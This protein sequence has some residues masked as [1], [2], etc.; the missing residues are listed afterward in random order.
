MECTSARCCP[1]RLRVQVFCVFLWM[2]D[3]YWYY[4]LF[5]LFMLVSFECTL[6]SQRLRNLRELRSLQTPKQHIQVYRC[7][8]SPLLY[9][10]ALNWRERAH[11]EWRRCAALPS[12]TWTRCGKWELLPGEALFPGDV[13]SIGRPS[14]GEPG[15]ASAAPQRLSP[16]A[17]VP[18]A[19]ACWRDV[20]PLCRC[21]R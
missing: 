15:A 4:S 13:I 20:L 12:C 18:A 1:L 19:V 10:H 11:L 17:P 5:T 16:A 21:G 7:A 6:V 8:P 9:L 3:E 2:M 14:G